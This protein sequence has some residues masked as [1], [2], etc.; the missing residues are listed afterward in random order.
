MHRKLLL[1]SGFLLVIGESA[2]GE[3]RPVTDEER[4]KLVAAVTAEGCTAGR[5]E[6][7]EDGQLQADDVTCSDDRQ[8]DLEF[9]TSFKV[10]K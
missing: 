5:F 3:D 1:F 10:I 7:D 2:I 9:D 8:Y 4:A 6:F